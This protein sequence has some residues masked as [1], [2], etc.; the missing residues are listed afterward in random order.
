MPSWVEAVKLGETAARAKEEIVRNKLKQM[1]NDEVIEIDK[2][3]KPNFKMLHVTEAKRYWLSWE[4][5][6]VVGNS[7][8]EALRSAGWKGPKEKRV[9]EQDLWTNL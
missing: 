5:T 1:T 4:E 3:L 2:T 6:M 8:E 7:W 9:E